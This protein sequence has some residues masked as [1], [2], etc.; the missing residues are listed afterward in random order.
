MKWGFRLKLFFRARSSGAVTAWGFMSTCFGGA[1]AYVL[2]F[3]KTK[4][5]ESKFWPAR[6]KANS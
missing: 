1:S 2:K 6:Q 4:L 5:Y 3:D